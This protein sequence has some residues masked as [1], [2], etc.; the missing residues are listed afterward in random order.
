MPV[1]EVILVVE[2]GELAVV[3]GSVSGT[4]YAEQIGKINLVVN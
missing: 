3:I 4:G 1:L 2:Y